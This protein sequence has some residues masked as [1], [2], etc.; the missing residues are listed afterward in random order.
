MI[1]LGLDKLLR[2]AYKSF[3]VILPV[4]FYFFLIYYLAHKEEYRHIW[5]KKGKRIFLETALLG[6][7]LVLMLGMYFLQEDTIYSYDYAGHWI[8]SLRLKEI[9]RDN[10]YGMFSLLYDSFLHSDYSFL[11]AYLS[12]PVMLWGNSYAYFA[13]ANVVVFILPF[14][15]IGNLYFYRYYSGRYPL[16]LLLCMTFYPLYY[17]LFWGVADV[18]GLFFLSLLC[19]L[20]LCRDEKE[21]TQSDLWLGNILVVIVILFRR[22]YLYPLVAFY[23]LLL[24]RYLY[25]YRKHYFSKEGILSFGKLLQMGIYALAIFCLFFGEFVKK[26]VTNQ[27]AEQYALYNHQGKIAAFINY[28]SIP[29]IVLMIVGLLS[30]YHKKKQ[31]HLLAI[32]FSIFFLLA[33]FWRVQSL[34]YHHYGMIIIPLLMAMV[35]GLSALMYKKWYL[36]GFTIIVFVQL[37]LIFFLPNRQLPFLTTTKKI[38]YRI[39]YKQ[40]VFA[41]SQKLRSLTQEEWQSAYLA[42]GSAVLNDD[43]IRNVLLPDLNAPRIDSAVVDLRDGFP[44]D[45]AN[46]QYVVTFDPIQ[47]I[48][49]EYQKIYDIISLALWREPLLKEYYQVIDEMS[50]ADIQ[51]KIY[52]RTK[53]L[54]SEVKHYFY[55][56]VIEVYPDKREFFSYILE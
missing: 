32:L 27:Y 22:W 44:R 17:T 28:L 47:Y 20:W 37:V 54:S 29:F 6:L 15:V 52:E 42:S 10:P 35:E 50:V 9:F 34:E 5:K 23:G 31:T 38:P 46:I 48:R 26:I 1:S 13:L 30:F 7:F 18:G 49:P 25:G 53:E 40:E 12:L 51:V 2:M 33:L 24:I 41:L 55:E 43:M 56:K 39:G 36:V 4:L 3:V 21:I 11:P 19:G 14:F 16:F 45:F 8:R